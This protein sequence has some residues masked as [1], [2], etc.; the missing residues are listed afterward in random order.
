MAGALIIDDDS[1][2]IPPALREAN[3]HEKVMVFATILYDTTRARRRHRRV[4]PRQSENRYAVPPGQ[5]RM[6]LGEL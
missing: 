2:K 1:T 6:H 5:V 4:L 3:K